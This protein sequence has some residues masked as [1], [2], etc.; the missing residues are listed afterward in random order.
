MGV[1]APDLLLTCPTAFSASLL[2]NTGPRF[3]FV[4]ERGLAAVLAVPM[5]GA[6]ATAA[7]VGPSLAMP[8]AGS[9]I[10]AGAAAQGGGARQ[11]MSAEGPEQLQMLQQ[12]TL[13]SGDEQQQLLPAGAAQAEP[14]PWPPAADAQADPQPLQWAEQRLHLGLLLA[15]PDAEFVGR[16]GV[17]LEEYTAF[18]E[19]W[20]LGEG[21]QWA[22]TNHPYAGR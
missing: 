10:A 3:R 4:A 21:L 17:G 20:L 16:L 14:H 15:G 9:G 8:V 7:I 18:A 6:M 5:A 2:H 22:G 1:A 13:P 12:V 19:A 11:Q